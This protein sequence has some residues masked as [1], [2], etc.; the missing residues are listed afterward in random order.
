MVPHRIGIRP[1]RKGDM[2]RQKQIWKIC[3]GDD[4]AY[5]DFY[6]ANRYKEDETLL[7]LLD[8]KIVAMLTIIPVEV[9]TADGRTF[10][11]AMQYAVAT[12]PKYRGRGFA[13][14]LMAFCDGHLKQKRMEM[15]V[16]VPA[17][18]GLFVIFGKRGSKK[19]FLIRE[20]LIA[21]SSLRGITSCTASRSLIMSAS[22][23]DYNIRRNRQLKGHFYVAYRDEEISY[24]KK[25]SVR[26][27]ADI[28]T[29]DIEG[30]HGCAAVE[31]INPD[32]V[33][34]KELLM[35]QRLVLQSL[36]QI[37]GRLPAREYVLRLPAYQCADLGGIVRPF[38]MVKSYRQ[39]QNGTAP[40][41]YG[42]LGIAYD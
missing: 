33:L 14:R 24:Q 20:I 17:E 34:I 2:D 29:I 25:L 22:P 27:G 18:E 37:A 15:S 8:G 16:L 32:R 12:H 1:A 9:V 40:D 39:P 13:S 26:T 35:P 10:P 41:R 23:K 42:Y 21:A 30:M 4:D 11:S 6:F 28:Y 5:I 31:R 36:V 3:F 38:G 7:M 19:G